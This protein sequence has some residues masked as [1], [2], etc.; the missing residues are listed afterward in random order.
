MG[1]VP[2]HLKPA[3]QRLCQIICVFLGQN[4]EQLDPLGLTKPLSVRLTTESEKKVKSAT[5]AVPKIESEGKARGQT[6][7]SCCPE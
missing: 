1:E 6:L 3:S 2:A 4:G 7:P 5:T